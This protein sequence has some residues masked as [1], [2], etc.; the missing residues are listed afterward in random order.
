MASST[1]RDELTCF[2][3]LE[4]PEQPA[5]MRC[6]HL[7][8]QG[9]IDREM[10][11][12]EGTG[13]YKCPECKLQ[14]NSPPQQKRSFCNII[15][16]FLSS[17]P[18]GETPSMV[19]T[20]SILSPSPHFQWCMLCEECLCH[21]HL[22]GHISNQNKMPEYYCLGDYA[23]FC[24]LCAT[25]FHKVQQMVPLDESSKENELLNSVVKELSSSSSSE[26][27]DRIQGLKKQRRAEGLSKKVSLVLRDLMKYIEALEKKVLSKISRQ[28]EQTSSPC[29]DEIQELEA[30]KDVDHDEKCYEEFNIFLDEDTAGKNILIL[31]DEKSFYWKEVHTP[32]P[33]GPQRF[34]DHQ[35]LSSSS[36]ST[37]RHFWTVEASKWGY[38]RFGMSYPSIAR[39]GFRSYIGCNKKSWVLCK[40]NNRYSVMHDC[41]VEDLPDKF[42]CQRFGVFLDYEAG[43][44]SFYELSDPIR[45][46]HTFHA[47]FTE[48]LHAVFRL[49]VDS[50]GE[51]WMML[52]SSRPYGVRYC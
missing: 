2:I 51:A 33:K 43:N 18:D 49:W 28:L 41:K 8:C 16:F 23:Y 27:E 9:C 7:F 17:L 26:A 47:A 13:L 46:L 32:K 10:K 22:R 39:K 6:G 5:M 31:P 19:C 44:L 30:K 40:W 25:K 38:W 50:H 4:V 45:H 3:C 42:T 48:P 37:G 12:Q 15:H 34:K 21:G 1:L 52:R 35:V 14:S 29:H 20:D 36:F 24:S 11:A